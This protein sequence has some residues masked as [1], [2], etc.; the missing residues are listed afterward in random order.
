MADFG[1]LNFSTSFNPTSAFPLDAR[2]Y[3]EG[4]TALADAEAAAAIAE[5]VG[6][7]NTVYHYGMKLLVNQGGVYTW[8]RITESGT[9]EAEGTGSAADIR[10]DETLSYTNGVLS[11]NTATEPDPDNTLPITAAAVAATVGN[12]EILLETI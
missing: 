3:F 2:C 7:T 10:T 5:D 12:I 6:S 4:D 1:K 9:L 11:V 8:Y